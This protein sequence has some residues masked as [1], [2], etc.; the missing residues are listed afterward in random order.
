MRIWLV[1]SYEPLPGVDGDV[2]LLRYG[3]LGSRLAAL[4]H[5]VSF[6]TSTFDHVRKRQRSDSSVTV[7]LA[8][9]LTGQLVHAP[10]YPRNRS[11]ARW[12]HNRILGK[13]FLTR[14]SREREPEIIVACLHAVE[15][16]ERVIEYA[17]PRG[18]P[19]VVDIVDRWPDFYL[20]ALPPRIRSLAKWAL[21]TEYARSRRVL[22]AAR[23][24]TAVSESYLQWGLEVARRPRRGD[25]RPF[26]LSYPTSL[27]SDSVMTGG[28]WK[29][30]LQMWGV[31]DSSL[32]VAFLG[33]FAGSYDVETVLD[34]AKLLAE[35]GR[36]DVQIVLGG[37]GDKDASLRKRARDL[38]GVIL[39]G[40]LDREAGQCLLNRASVGLA[41]YTRGTFQSLP[42]KP[43]EYMAHG[44]AILNSLPGELSLLLK[45]ERIGETYAP[46]D[47][48]ALAG[49]IEWCAD[50]R[51]ETEAMGGRARALFDR[52]F[53]AD[54][55]YSEFGA[56]VLDAATR[57]RDPESMCSTA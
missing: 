2:R 39:P 54:I 49:L 42:Y 16:S 25:D 34:A 17:H 11:I 7:E 5:E 26:V 10:G 51:A 47:A 33:M 18:I 32:V 13:E 55:V 45:D 3:M 48:V 21:M 27:N 57:S 37:A 31:R 20:T 56:H 44:L 28:R 50:H 14:A 9:G 30:L 6:W 8:P 24:I 43:F 52:K 41:A 12:R 1:V 23:C 46:G 29:E 4:G 40:W 19:V 15:L 22:R 36:D 53:S 35:R 38:P